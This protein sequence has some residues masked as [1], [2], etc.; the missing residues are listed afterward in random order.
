MPLEENYIAGKYSETQRHGQIFVGD[1]CIRTKTTFLRRV[2]FMNSGRRLK[3]SMKCLYAPS[4]AW[5]LLPPLTP[6]AMSMDLMRLS[7]WNLC[8]FATW[9]ILFFSTLVGG[10][11]RCPL[12]MVFNIFSINFQAFLAP[13]NALLHN[14]N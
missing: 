4:R 8:L 13:F 7:F 10:A 3:H 5:L 12:C 14:I 9:L 1:R 2:F 6:R 11:A